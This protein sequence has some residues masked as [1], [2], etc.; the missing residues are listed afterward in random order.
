MPHRASSIDSPRLVPHLAS[1]RASASVADSW[2][3]WQ[4]GANGHPT[5]VNEHNLNDGTME[6]GKENRTIKM[7]M[8]H[9]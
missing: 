1:L 5:L 8:F 4:A 3:A 9:G 2:S 7:A 6:M